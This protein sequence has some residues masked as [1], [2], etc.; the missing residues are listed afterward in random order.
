MRLASRDKGANKIAL[1]SYRF[2]DQRMPKI[3][4][5]FIPA[6][7]SERREYI[8]VG[9][10]D[11]DIVVV[12]PNFAIFD[13]PI[14]IFGILS[15]RMHMTW[16]KALAGRLETRIRYSSA[17]CYNTFPFPY[18]SEKQKLEL[19]ELVFGILDCREKHSE[20]TI[21]ELYDPDKMPENLRYAHQQMDLAIEKCYKIHPFKNDE[22]R[23]ELLFN[24]YAEMTNISYGKE[25]KDA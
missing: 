8:P 13:A 1:R 14:Y 5:L 6:V 22:E 7:S 25:T 3:Q 16:V 20:R 17:L 4:S 15:S 23:L 21:A 19:E 9:Y 2:R 24:L 11:K 10:L 18:I 12:A